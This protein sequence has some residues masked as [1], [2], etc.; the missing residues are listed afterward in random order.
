[1]ALEPDSNEAGLWINPNSQVGSQGL[2]ALI[3]GVS[4]YDHLN[5]GSAPAP[6][7][8]GLGQLSASAL[9]AYRFF[10][11]LQTA[12]TLQDWPVARVRLLMSPCRQG[13]DESI[14]DELSGCDT[15]ICAHSPEATFDNCRRAI[16]NWYADMEELRAPAL[17]RSLFLFSGHGM[18]RRQNH[19]LLIPADYLKP[20][21]RLISN[22][23]STRNLSDALSYLTCVSTHVLLLDGCRNDIDGLRT[24]G[25]GVL[26]DNQP[27]AVNPLFEKGTLYATAS[28]LRAYSPKSGGLSLFGQAL[29][30]GLG[31]KPDPKLDEAPIELIQKHQRSAVEINKLGSYMKGRVAA[32]IKAANE[33]VVQIVRSEVA[34]PDPDRPIELAELVKEASIGFAPGSSKRPQSTFP[35]E[36]Q[37]RPAPDAWFR[38]RYQQ[39]RIAIPAMPGASRQEH[40]NRFQAIFGSEAVTFPWLDKLRVIGLSTH[41]AFGHEVVKVLS[42]AQAVATSELHRL[43]ISFRVAASDPIGHL[44]VIENQRQRR[45]CSV[46]PNDLEERTFQLEIDV[47]DRDYVNFSIYLSPQNDGPAGRIAAAWEQLRARDVV[48]A[49]GR[50]E[51]DVESELTNAFRDGEEALRLKLRSP[52][53]AAVATVL[54]LKGNQ[55]E[56]M[57]DWA[58]NLANWFPAM[59]DGVVLWTEQCRRMRADRTLDPELIRWFVH[60]LSRRSLPLTADGFGLAIDLVSDVVRGRLDA[61]EATRSAAR[62][63]ADRLKEPAL[64]FRDTGL[65]YTFAGFPAEW[66]P[67]LILGPPDPSRLPSPKTRVRGPDE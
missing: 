40:I 39:E 48:T 47:E 57:H 14:T 27:I 31:N 10:K 54:L 42:S 63:L 20:P 37:P 58:R 13:A 21:G 45:F 26:N 34:S 66:N 51:S 6:E 19:L 41:Q 15:A 25:T 29:L 18:E 44:I 22:A 7:T 30:D 5:A 56:R 1:M 59:P 60:E 23:I 49:A 55:F 50:L 67:M 35:D 65:F 52:L 16:E 12:Y 3:I 28:G 46:L 8:Y 43:K 53:A 9:T 33:R 62:A 24:E 4:R 38:E 17:G 2:H 32:L 61:D 11:W 36:K 64:Y